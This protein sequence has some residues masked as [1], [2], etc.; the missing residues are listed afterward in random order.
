[1]IPLSPKRLDIISLR[2]SFVIG[3]L[4]FIWS[5]TLS[6]IIVSSTKVWLHSGRHKSTFVV[7]A[8]TDVDALYIAVQASFH[9]R[10][11]CVVRKIRRVPMEEDWSQKYRI[12]SR[13]LFHNF[14][15][16]VYKVCYVCRTKINCSINTYCTRWIWLN[17]QFHVF[18]LSL[19]SISKMAV[20]CYHWYKRTH[21]RSRGRYPLT[22]SLTLDLQYY[23]YRSSLFSCHWIS[24]IGS[25]AGLLVLSRN[26]VGPC[27]CK[28]QY[29]LAAFLQT[30]QDVYGR[31]R[32]KHV[33]RYHGFDCF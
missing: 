27:L 19:C 14:L 26:F 17:M 11:E 30:R 10:K 21:A 23:W 2:W 20:Y 24:L 1:M 25:A 9:V 29:L 12:V 8:N 18:K 22:R 31:S 3:S 16:F 4:F 15:V 32:E 5:V 28:C 7:T 33:W 6:L 13:W